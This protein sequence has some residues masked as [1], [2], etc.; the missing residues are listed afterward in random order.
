MSEE[1][2]A[3]FADVVALLRELDEDDL[4]FD[5]PPPDLWAA[6]ERDVHR[7][8]AGD[9][10]GGDGGDGS[11][12]LHGSNVVDISSRRRPGRWIAAAAAAVLIFVGVGSYVITRS[13]D[14]SVVATARLTWDPGAFDP[15]GADA[16]AQ[17]ELIEHDGHYELRLTD[18]SLP[19]SLGGSSDLELWLI[20][21]DQAGDITDIA[22]VALVNGSSPGTYEVPPTIDPKVNTIVDIS[23][24]PRD[25]D[26]KHSGRSILRGPLEPV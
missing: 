15:L 14:Q 7:E 22:P 4:R 3:E 18:A 23:V 11:A 9:T 21:A 20:A 19:T 16:A 25:G 12:R 8:W 17:A 5:P 13:G 24:E 10:S 6:I 2:E 1:P 26:A